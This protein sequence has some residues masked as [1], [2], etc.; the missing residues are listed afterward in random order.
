[1]NRS[2]RP[3]AEARP[4]DGTFAGA[5]KL[6]LQRALKMTLVERL[7]AVEEM[8]QSSQLIRHAAAKRHTGK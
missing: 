5:R 6:Y 3:L 2:G 7:R 1:M 4:G 8:G